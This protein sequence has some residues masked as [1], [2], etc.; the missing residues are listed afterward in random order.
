MTRN[1]TDTQ[2]EIQQ[3]LAPL[4]ALPQW[5]AFRREPDEKREGHFRKPP[6]NPRTGEGAKANDPTTWGTYTEAV[7]YAKG[8]GLFDADTDGKPK[9]GIGFEFANGYAGIDLDH[10][11][12]ADGT[13]KEF[14]REV[15]ETL[16][17]YTEY[18][19]SGTGL[20]ILLTV[21]ETP[22][23]WTHFF[24][25]VKHKA[26]IDGGEI[27]FY[28]QARFFTVTGKPYGE[29]KQIRER[30]Q[31][32]KRIAEKYLL[33][34]ENK[35]SKMTAQNSPVNNFPDTLTDRELLDKMFNSENG[36]AIEAL[37]RGDIS[38]YDNDQ[39]RA[40]LALCNYLA[41]WTNGGASRMDSLFRN[42]GLMRLKWDERHK[43]SQTYG[44]MTIEKAI[45]DTKNG[46]TGASVPLQR[47]NNN[48]KTMSYQQKENA[49]EKLKNIPLPM[50][51][52]EYIKSGLFQNA[53][54]AFR[55]YPEISTGFENLDREQEQ[56]IS[57]FY[58][59]GAIPSIGKTSFCLQM[60]DNI[61]SLGH[62]VL[63]IALEQTRLELTSKTLS[64]TT[65]QMNSKFIRTMAVTSRNIRKGNYS[66]LQKEALQK[67]LKEYMNFADDKIIIDL[68]FTATISEV[69]CVIE[70][71]I[72]QTGIKPVV[73]VDYLQVIKPDI[74]VKGATLREYIDSNIGELKKLQSNH[75]LIMIV[76]S[77]FNR[78]NYTASVDFS[79]FKETGS[80]EYT[81]DVVWGLQ[82]QVM[83]SDEVFK[84]EKK[85]REQ[86]N[87]LDE[88][89]Q[90]IPR[91]ILLK[92]LKNRYGRSKYECGFCYDPRFD[93]F[94]VD[95]GF[96]QDKEKKND[97][98][99][100]Y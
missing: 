60:A 39:S 15:V 25:N 42:S 75:N 51:D 98:R 100:I 92:N 7:N 20:H 19:P 99:A 18:S 24:E 48:D 5:V 74:D 1:L 44:A 68:P 35:T 52:Y 34:T 93:L 28:T 65:A 13:L 62:K 22:E 69:K 64:R 4:K 57:G 58:I 55:E 40:D 33:K 14:A 94:T 8:N 95:V 23:Q 86:R 66:Q 84:S 32:A 56:L 88:E 36:R 85:E 72:E 31:E 10:V 37:Y 59:L 41:F 45:Q 3:A 54:T 67:A 96:E 82:Y 50:S 73:F 6:I 43:G 87:K 53:L 80:I 47:Q 2:Q 29:A 97:D 26:P 91:K 16:D 90:K 30:T 77:S 76:I 61:A 9:G 12:N 70:N 49:K 83:K 79:S 63:Y 11:V 89:A 81:A 17:S 38:G 27:E 78:T 21:E 46:F 71:Y